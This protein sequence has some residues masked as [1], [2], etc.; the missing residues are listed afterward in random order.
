MSKQVN[1][2]SKFWKRMILKM[3]N[4]KSAYVHLFWHDFTLLN[5]YDFMISDRLVNEWTKV[6]RCERKWKQI[7]ILFP[8]FC[9]YVL[10]GG[11]NSKKTFFQ[12][13]ISSNIKKYVLPP[14][15]IDAIYCHCL[16]PC[17]LAETFV[18]IWASNEINNSK[19]LKNHGN[20][21]HW[22]PNI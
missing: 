15:Q 3:Q 1:E 14:Y 22:S 9:F 2:Q 8:L 16:I 6:F 12:V 21:K 17:Y 18:Y 19:I 20:N 7:A 4:P 13:Q 10:A 11:L 5:F